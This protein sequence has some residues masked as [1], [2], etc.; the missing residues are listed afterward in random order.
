MVSG[1]LSMFFSLAAFMGML[2]AALL[3]FRTE[4]RGHNSR[5]LAYYIICFVLFS[6][7][8]LLLSSGYLLQ[9]PYLFRVT[10]PLSYAV[11]PLVYLYVRGNVYSET[12]FRKWDGLLF[13]PMV[14]HAFELL[15]FYTMKGKRAYMEDFYRNMNKGVEQT[16]GILPAYVH[17]VLL[18]L[19][20]AILLYRAWIILRS[21]KR[22]STTPLEGRNKDLMAWLFFFLGINLVFLGLLA[23]H[24]LIFRLVPWNTFL[25]TS[26]EGAL[27][28][29]SAGVVLFFRPGI[30]YGF[31]G[32]MLVIEP[33]GEYAGPQ[34]GT[35]GESRGLT[36]PE[37]KRR[38]YLE[39]IR[40]HFAQKQPYLQPGYSLKQLSEE[41]SIP[42]SHLSFVI[43]H[44]Y[45]MNF[46][47]LV[48][49]FRVTYV[50]KLMQEPGAHTFTLEALAEQSGFSS[51]A[52]FSR[53][54]SRFAGCTPSEFFRNISPAPGPLSQIA[55]VQQNP[56]P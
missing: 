39:R 49:S 4:N 33:S 17:P 47:E 41:V 7:H 15:P 32:E 31:R 51:R 21:A 53:A 54:F 34:G 55:D 23:L 27:V 37:E 18:L 16:E 14:L 2:I 36:L 30:L 22:R 50:K 56:N 48:N 3:L 6:M 40:E 12:R 26:L 28:M 35:K 45:G 38:D 24:M 8:N 43:N 10:K 46:N 19:F 20:S 9:M 44:E 29:I 25:I 13:L 5:V 42:Y 1:L 11:A 52:T